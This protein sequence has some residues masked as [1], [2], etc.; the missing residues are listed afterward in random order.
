MTSGNARRRPALAAVAAVAAATPPLRAGP[1]GFGNSQAEWQMYSVTTPPGP[2]EPESGFLRKINR[3]AYTLHRVQRGEYGGDMIARKYGASLKGLQATNDNELLYLLPGQKIT[4]VNKPGYLY[5]VR[6]PRGESLDQI[7]RRF[8]K[9]A[10]SRQR[11]K[12]A[13]VEANNLPGAAL[14]NSY[15]FTQGARLLLPGVSFQFDTYRFPFKGFGWPRISS[16]FGM[17]YHPI[18]HRRIFHDGLDLPRPWG[19]PVYPSRSGTVMFTGWKNG[20]GNLIILKHRDGATTYYGHL[21]KIEVKP[22]DVVLRGKT[23]IGRVGS[24]GLST[25]PHLHFE[26]HDRFGRLVNPIRKIGRR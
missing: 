4:V 16:R 11:F 14:L 15:V 17:R 3:L 10:A 12:D 23:R 1:W 5:H 13:V 25:G 22:G 2:P 26:V 8:Y 19:S 21:S 7:A 20:Y 9:S 18:L 24:T 6:S